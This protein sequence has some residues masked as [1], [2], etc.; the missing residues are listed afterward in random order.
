MLTELSIKSLKPK[1]NPKTGQLIRAEYPDEG[2]TRRL[3]M[4]VQ[5]SGAKSWALRYRAA[6]KPAKYTLG[7]YP[8]ISI[9]TARKLAEEAIGKLAG[10]ND[11]AAAK[12]AARAA[13]EAKDHMADVAS[14]FVERSVKRS[15]GELWARETQRLLDVEILP[16]LG[17]KRIGEV[18][19]ADVHGLLDGIVDRGSGYTANRTLAVLRRMFNW[20]IERG[21]VDS[22]PVEKIKAPAPETARDRVLTD[23]EIRFAWNAFEKV[24]LPFGAVG[25]LLLLTGARRDEIAEGRWNEVD[26]AGKTWTIAKERSKNG[27]AHEIPLSGAV[28]EILNSLPRVEG[29]AGLV[30]TTT[31]TTPVSGFSRAKTSIDE[32]IVDLLRKDAEAR[33]DDPDGVEA[34]PSWVFH[35]LRRTCASGMAGIGIAPHVVEAILN[36]K[37]GTIKGV[38]AVYNRYSYASEKRAALDAWARRLEAILAGA[39]ASNVVPIAAARR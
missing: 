11:P 28:I 4:I 5:P 31:G 20:A 1:R 13:R 16:K 7:P 8:Q 30:F 19:R 18:R 27:V 3:Y 34:P 6:G 14:V 15:A 36:H 29:K 23:D 21:L 38:A 24:G 10:G 32:A 2:G 26:L 35:D 33:G 17:A 9:K 39:E 25:K 12:T 37:S 22:S